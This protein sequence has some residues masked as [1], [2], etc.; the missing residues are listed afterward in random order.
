MAVVFANQVHHGLLVPAQVSKLKLDTFLRKVVLSPGTR[1]STGL[2]EDHDFLLRH[3]FLPYIRFWAAPSWVRYV[4][5]CS[6]GV[7]RLST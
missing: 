3:E 2:A 5:A 4:W 7:R 1:W 6:A